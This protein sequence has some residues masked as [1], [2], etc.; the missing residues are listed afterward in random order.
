MNIYWTVYRRHTQIKEKKRVGEG[1]KIGNHITSTTNYYYYYLEFI[2]LSRP[3]YNSENNLFSF[4][5]VIQCHLVYNTRCSFAYAI[6]NRICFMNFNNWIVD[7]PIS[8]F[9]INGN[10]IFWYCVDIM[11]AAIRIFHKLVLITIFVKLIQ[12]HTECANCA[13]DAVAGHH[14]LLV[15]RMV[16]LVSPFLFF[17]YT[18]FYWCSVSKRSEIDS[19]KWRNERTRKNSNAKCIR[20]KNILQLYLMATLL[21]SPECPECLNARIIIIYLLINLFSVWVYRFPLEI[22]PKNIGFEW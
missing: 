9:F 17:P 4:V 8:M 14:S 2:S 6:A 1:T 20:A 13:N 19:G 11:N 7:Y 15:S 21:N 3:V 16:P 12:C 18:I 5:C 10:T 22:G